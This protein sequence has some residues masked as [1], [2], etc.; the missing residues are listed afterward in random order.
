MGNLVCKLDIR[1]NLNVNYENNKFFR[2]GGSY[3]ERGDVIKIG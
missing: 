2:G 3:D 1:K